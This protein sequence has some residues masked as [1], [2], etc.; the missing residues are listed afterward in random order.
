MNPKSSKIDCSFVENILFQS[1]TDELNKN[2]ID[3][4]IKHINACENC[5]SS[6]RLLNNFKQTMKVE[7][8]ENKIN[9]NPAILESLKRNFN[10]KSEK[11][12][13]FFGFIKDFFE[14]KIP[15]YQIVT[16]L[17]IIG[18]FSLFLNNRNQS[19]DSL[20]NNVSI[21]AAIDSNT[22]SIS[23]QNSLELIDSYKKGK[24]IVED[25][26]LSNF[27]QSSM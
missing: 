4:I 9:P 7:L 22:I 25:S 23:F 1:S 3:Q 8:S 16:A 11:K 13:S 10:F 17:L 18:A 15:V 20:N 21:I 2:E 14:L 24:S 5:Q 26:V 19:I 6:Q 12:N 27:I